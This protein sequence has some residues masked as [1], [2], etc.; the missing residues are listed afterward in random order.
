MPLDAA[1]P[2]RRFSV[3]AFQEARGRA[4]L[5]EGVSFEDAALA[6]LDACHPPPDADH[7]VSLIVEDCDSG[8]QQCFRVDLDT[9]RTAPCDES[10]IPSP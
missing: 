4:W 5:M 8:E 10:P 1:R 9:G 3:H 2:T 7:Q 6:F